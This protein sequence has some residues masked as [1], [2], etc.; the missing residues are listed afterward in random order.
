MNT[1]IADLKLK[2]GITP[3]QQAQVDEQ[4][5]NAKVTLAGDVL[6]IRQQAGIEVSGDD[7][8]ELMC[9]SIGRLHRE[10]IIAQDTAFNLK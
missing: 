10:V 6:R 7:F 3:L 4:L 1:T 5:K 8:D 9:L 2:I